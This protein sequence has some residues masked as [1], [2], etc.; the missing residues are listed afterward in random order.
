MAPGDVIIAPFENS[1]EGAEEVDVN[2]DL[3]TSAAVVAEYAS[4]NASNASNATAGHRH[5]DRSPFGI[6]DHARWT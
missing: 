1:V 4:K 3:V 5:G 6:L 2:V